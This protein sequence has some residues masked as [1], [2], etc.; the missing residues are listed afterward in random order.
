MDDRILLAEVILVA[1]L[2]AG[3][4]LS[5][6]MSARRAERRQA[7]LMSSSSQFVS[8]AIAAAD[9]VE[10]LE[11]LVEGLARVFDAEACA[12]VAPTEDGLRL[13]ALAVTGYSVEGELSVAA[14]EGVVGRVFKTGEPAVV[15]DVSKDPDYMPWVPRVRSMIAVP[16]RYKGR[17]IGVFNIESSRRRYRDKDL[18][19]LVP[20]A[21]Q[22]AAAL[23]NIELRITAET[24]AAEEERV[25]N[26]LQAVSAVVMAGIASSSDLDAALQSMIQE[27]SARMGWESLAVVLFADDGLLY[28]HA[29][30]GYP[31]HSTVIAF[32]PGQGIIG[33]VAQSGKSLLIPD[34]TKDPAYLDVVTGTRAEMCAPMFV[35]SEVIGVLNAESPR[36]DAFTDE[37]LKMLSNLARQMAVVIERTRL[38]DIERAALARLREADQLKDD[39]IATVSHE[40]R[41]PL[42]SIKGFAQTLLAR[43]GALSAADQKDFLEIIA[44][45]CDRLARIVDTLLLVSRMEAGEIGA[46]PSFVSVAEML[47]DAAEASSGEDRFV[48]Q[49]DP[50][51]GIVTDHF[52]LHHIL[53]NIFENACKYSPDGSSVLVRARSGPETLTVEVT[54]QG[55][56]VADDMRDRIFERFRRVAD[57]GRSSIPGTGLGLYIARRF[58]RDLGGDIAVERG[59]TMPHTGARFILTLPAIVKS[60]VDEAV[61]A[62]DGTR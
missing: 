62:R 21:D 15:R 36:L 49:A 39:F 3:T 10:A 53:R 57:P 41:T 13:K 38:A 25:R 44:R 27:I 7:A 23:E 9:S 56:G 48:L 47:R 26:E 35:G 42:T 20:L 40:L 37:D 28:T 29:Y 61:P 22:I 14:D 54:D 31:L 17:T 5:V 24:K 2:A 43:G 52:R 33:T 4:I 19:M 30:Y 16:L 34:V 58:A 50:A 11:G 59:D 6:L 8:S 32:H 12:V 18:A 46:K 60:V 45:H 51:S 55:A 1:L